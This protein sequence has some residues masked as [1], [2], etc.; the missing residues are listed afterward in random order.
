MRKEILQTNKERLNSREVAQL[1]GKKWTELPID[2]KQIYLEQAEHEKYKYAEEIKKFSGPT[3]L[4][5]RMQMKITH[6][7]EE[8]KKKIKKPTN[9]YILFCN[10]QRMNLKKNQKMTLMDQNTYLAERYI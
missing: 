7:L 1:L 3:C 9:A 5:K 2:K 8:S 10:V 4:S 6:N